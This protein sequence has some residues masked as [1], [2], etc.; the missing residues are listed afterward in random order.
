[1][2]SQDPQTRSINR[3]FLRIFAPIVILVSIVISILSAWN[4]YQ[5]NKSSRIESQKLILETFTASVRQPLIQGSLIE[6]KIRANELTKNKQVPCVEISTPAE[7]VVRCQK[8]LSDKKGLNRVESDLYFSEEN[9]KS[10]AHLAVIFDNSDLINESW[11]KASKN[12]GGFI[13]LAAI[14][15]T[16]LSI[17][18]SRMK[19]ELNELMKI[20]GVQDGKSPDFHK[21][22]ISE[23]SALGKALVHQLEVAKTKAEAKAALDIARQVAHDI[24]SPIVSLQIA[25]NAAQTQIDPKIKNV[26]NN[27]AQRISDIADDVINQ[28]ISPFQ[29]VGSKTSIQKFPMSVDLALSEMIAEKIVMCKQ[30]P[31]VSINAA[32]F[33]DDVF[34]EMRVSDFKRIISNLV[35]NS[36][37]ALSGNG[38]VDISC[39]SAQNQCCITILDNGIGIPESQLKIVLEKG[40]SFG[41]PSGKGLGLQWAKRTVEQHN[42]KLLIS[43]KEGVGTEVK[44][45]LPIFKNVKLKTEVQLGLAAN[46]C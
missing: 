38:K 45:F 4:D 2:S 1:M 11:K 36:I 37:Q 16:V 10:F 40:G 35:D 3:Y 12:V 7:Q 23:F 19:T 26:L 33:T 31:S 24:R 20:A 6:A 41:K 34:I 32:T 27:S 21:F 44:I 18:F 15:F 9:K 14:L 8:D 13:L 43:S 28:H 30:M 17:G 46:Q 22:K 29:D 39:A 5:I 42:G 25:L